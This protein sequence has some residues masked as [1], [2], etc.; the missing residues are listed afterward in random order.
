VT[1]VD[2]VFQFSDEGGQQLNSA[3]NRGWIG[4]FKQVVTVSVK[5]SN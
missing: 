4:L 1:V 5:E 3:S 2:A